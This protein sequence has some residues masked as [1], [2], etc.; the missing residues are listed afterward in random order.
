VADT[1]PTIEIARAIKTALAAVVP[2]GTTIYARGVADL[3]AEG[4][5]VTGGAAEDISY[6]LVSIVISKCAPQQYRSR[7][8]AYPVTISAMTW[9]TEDKDQ[10]V[11][12]TLANKL[13]VWMA[14]PPSLTLS[15]CHFDAIVFQGD[16]Q[17][18][19]AGLIQGMTWQASVKTLASAT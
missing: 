4:E 18:D 15:L 2:A 10:T 8:R 12:Y 17:T 1:I 14:G 19:D 11:L 9:Y 7:L 5:S 3:L 13:S 16:P 6:P